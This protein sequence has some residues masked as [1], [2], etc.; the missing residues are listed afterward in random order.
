[1]PCSN[2]LS[3]QYLQIAASFPPTCRPRKPAASPGFVPA[4]PVRTKEVRDSEETQSPVH[5]EHVN[6]MPGYTRGYHA[7]RRERHRQPRARLSPRRARRGPLG[8]LLSLRQHPSRPRS[9][10]TSS[11]SALGLA[12]GGHPACDPVVRFMCLSAEAQVDPLDEALGDLLSSCDSLHRH[13]DRVADGLLA[14]ALS[15]IGA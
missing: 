4:S 10:T 13:A 7:E 6:G 8:P 14:R 9:R 3:H 12:R 15:S 2:G 11:R 5:E 1:M